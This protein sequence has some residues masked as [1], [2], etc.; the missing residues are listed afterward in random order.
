[1]QRIFFIARH[2]ETDWNL[3]RR[4]QG[5][6]D[7]PLNARGREQAAALAERLRGLAVKIERVV[8]SDLARA[9]ETGEIVAS[10]LGIPQLVSDAALRE[11]CFGVFEGLTLEECESRYPEHWSSYRSEAKIPPPGAEPFEAVAARMSE[12][13]NRLLVH[14]AASPNA[15]VIGHGGAMRA[16]LQ[17]VSGATYPPLENAALFRFVHATTGFADVTH[18]SSSP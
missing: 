10:C 14:D 2:G 6:T 15:L 13:L 3:A 9:R 17:S 12:A 7:I 11:R 5:H 18:I 16:F 4:W 8:T 1:M